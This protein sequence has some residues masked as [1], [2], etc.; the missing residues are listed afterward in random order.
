MKNFGFNIASSRQLDMDNYDKESYNIVTS[1]VP[2]AKRCL[3]CGACTATCT[4]R[5]HTD[6][7][8][9]FVHLMF[10]RGQF[11]NLAE[12]LDKCMLCGKCRLVCPRGVNTRA[13]IYNMR[14]ILN[15]LN[16]KNIK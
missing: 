9:R 16:Y 14:I 6:F 5:E 11:E 10:R 15:D 1:K 7:N 2:S 3:M 12:E 8:F 13:I 4:A